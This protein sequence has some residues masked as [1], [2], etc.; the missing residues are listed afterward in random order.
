MEYKVGQLIIYKN[1]E[2]VEIGMITELKNDGAF[3][4]YH[5][6][7]TAAFT[8]YNLIKAIINDNCIIKTNLGGGV[9]E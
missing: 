2:R 7:E 3:I 5:S 9:D 8:N 4:F 1:N 6:G